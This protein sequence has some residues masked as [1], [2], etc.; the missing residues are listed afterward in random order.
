MLPI[1]ALLARFGLVSA[2]LPYQQVS[3][4]LNFNQS[5]HITG[6]FDIYTGVYYSDSI[7]FFRPTTP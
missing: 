3:P 5:R 4:T 2:T 6:P 7:D 1:G